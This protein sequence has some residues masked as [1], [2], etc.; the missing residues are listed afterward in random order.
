MIFEIETRTNG[1]RKIVIKRENGCKRKIIN[2]NTRTVYTR[3]LAGQIK[4]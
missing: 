4:E 1:R 2:N 3:T